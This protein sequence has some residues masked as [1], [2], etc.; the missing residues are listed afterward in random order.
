MGELKSGSVADI[1]TDEYQLCDGGTPLSNDL[2]TLLGQGNNVP[3]LRNRF[4][5]GAGSDSG[6][7]QTFDADDG[8]T[9]GLLLES[10]WW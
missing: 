3:D 6:T 8:T 5:V 10:N 4:I 2:Q 9:S 1:P 7:G